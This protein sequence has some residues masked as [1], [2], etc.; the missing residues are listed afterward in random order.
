MKKI[1]D[2]NRL[3][4]KCCY[5]YYMDGLGQ[6][7]I[8]DQLGISRATVSRLLKAGKENGVVRIELDNPDSILYG[9]LERKI[10]QQL[11]LKEVLIVDEM[12]LESKADHMQRYMRKHLPIWHASSTTRITSGC[13]WE[14][15]CI[16]WQ[17]EKSMWRRLIV[18]LF[19]LSVVSVH[20]LQSDED[21]IPT[22]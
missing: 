14:K 17:M 19:P 8:C 3:I 20:K 1:V 2:D 6:K 15:R 18:P 21:I 16:I 11:G 13:R 12:E 7:E 9:E 10:E 4:Y 5:L 22:K